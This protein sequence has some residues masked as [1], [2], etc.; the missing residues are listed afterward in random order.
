MEY[1]TLGRTNLK[2]SSLGFGCS[3]LGGVFGDIDEKEAID[4]VHNAIE[5]ILFY[6]QNYLREG[7]IPSSSG[8]PLLMAQIK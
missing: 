2:I 6:Y 3:P 8:E 5:V 7:P 4:T 1:R